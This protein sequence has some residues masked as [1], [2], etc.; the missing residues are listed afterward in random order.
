MTRHIGLVGCARRKLAYAAPA[1]VLFTSP[2]FTLASRYCA[3]TCALWFVLSAKHGLLD[4]AAVIEPYDVTLQGLGRAGRQAWAHHVLEQVRQRGLLD[5]R[6]CFLLHAGAAY[7]APLAEHLHAEQ[8][9]RGLG[10][11]RRLAWYRRQLAALPE[12]NTP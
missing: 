10:I 2:L 3:A 8:P 9:L 4:P 6:Q 7:A 1:A 11:G 5:G 12:R